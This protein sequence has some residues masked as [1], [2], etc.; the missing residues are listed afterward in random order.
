MASVKLTGDKVALVDSE[1]LP[2]VQAKNWWFMDGYAFGKENG[3]HIAL[4]N[5]LMRPPEGKQVDHIN[6][7]RLDN[8]RSNLRLCTKAENLRNKCTYKNNL[9]GFKGVRFYRWN[10]QEK[11]VARIRMDGKLI[12]I[13]TFKT[14][15]LAAK[16]YDE[17][18]KRIFGEFAGTNFQEK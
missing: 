2:K 4:H 17:K 18:A 5:F 14:A 12:H 16:A 3:K 10:K 13:G 15:E 11:W 6:R 8:R 7:D 9:S 1:D